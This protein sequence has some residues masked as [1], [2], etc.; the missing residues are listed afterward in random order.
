MNIVRFN[1]TLF[2]PDILV[3]NSG[4]A[5]RFVNSSNLT[6]RVGSRPECLSSTYYSSISQPS[7]EGEGSTYE[8]DFTQPGIFSYQNIPS[9]GGPIYGIVFVR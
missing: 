6:M 1:G 4:E 3:V 5:V 9:T 7:A 8:F 2:S